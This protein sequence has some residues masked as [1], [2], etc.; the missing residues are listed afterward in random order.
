MQVS[1]KVSQLQDEYRVHKPN[2]TQGRQYSS[3]FHFSSIFRV[4]PEL[5]AIIASLSSRQT[6]ARLCLLSRSFNGIFLPHL[7]SDILEPAL[8][9]NQSL[10]I[11][12]TISKN[13]ASQSTILR[14]AS[15]IQKLSV[16]DA[17]SGIDLKAAEL[18][19]QTQSAVQALHN[20]RLLPF[21]DTR[22]ASVLRVLHWGLAAG[23]DE[24]GLILS[25]PGHFPHLREFMQ[26]PGLEVLGLSLTE[27]AY[28]RGPSKGKAAKLYYKLAEVLQMLQFSS[29]L[30][31]TLVFNLHLDYCGSNFPKV[32]FS[33]LVS[34]INFKADVS[35]LLAA[36]PKIT[37][38]AI[39]GC[40]LV[41]VPV[42]KAGS[43]PQLLQSFTGSFNQCGLIF[44]EN[45]NL[46]RV[47]LVFDESVDHYLIQSTPPTPHNS[48]TEATIR[49]AIKIS[50]SIGL[51]ILRTIDESYRQFITSLPHLQ[52]L[53]VQDYR[54]RASANGLEIPIAKAFPASGYMLQVGPFLPS[55]SRLANVMVCL[56]YD[57]FECHNCESLY[58]SDGGYD[59]VHSDVDPEDYDMQRQ[60]PTTTV[61]YRFLVARNSG[62]VRLVLTDTEVSGYQG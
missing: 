4:A 36:H 39:E 35:P 54:T 17:A 37:H 6:I 27:D 22:G 13:P 8:T 58:G 56:W 20:L 33:D 47:E 57:D 55:L 46:E 32:A 31:H 61:I 51:S 3:A 44:T 53:R 2:V 45:P 11:L 21:S 14:P 7:Y 24:L 16:Q 25:V 62:A 5:W 29:P 23:I 28:G 1:M 52:Y 19:A 60:P 50:S 9:A 59:C 49:S 40:G 41:I 34:A 30:L 15:C 26:I 38:L 42:E 43:M 12:T 48:L 18:K 10:L